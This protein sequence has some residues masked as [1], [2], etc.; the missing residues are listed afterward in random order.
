MDGAIAEGRVF[1]HQQMGV[2][3]SEYICGC[4]LGDLLADVM[5]FVASLFQGFPVA[6][7]LLVDGILVQLAFSDIGS[8]V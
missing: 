1:D 5:Q 6:L 8:L 7:D 4:G 3:E 2:D